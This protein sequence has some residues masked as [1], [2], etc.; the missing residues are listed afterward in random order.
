MP[1]SKLRVLI[2][3]LG[4]IG[5]RH[6]DNLATLGASLEA[7]SSRA[8]NAA[9]GRPLTLHRD[10]AQ[11]LKGRPD[12]VF[13]A[14]PT[15]LHAEY[16]AAAL[17]AGCHVYLEKPAAVSA[18]QA[19]PLAALARARKRVLAVGCQWRFNPCLE[20]V[21]QA[22]SEGELGT[23]LSASATMGEYL[24][25]Y[26]PG[27]DYRKGY[28]ARKDLGGGVLLTQIHDFNYL[29]WLF[30]PF[31]TAYAVGGKVSSLE[32]DVEDSVT[33]LLKSRAGVPVSAHVD[34]IQRKK[35]RSLTI[36]G[37]EG[38]LVWDAFENRLDQGARSWA[39][40]PLDRNAIFTAAVADF[41]ACVK[42][43]GRPRT[44]IEDAIADLAI[45]D[46][47]RQSMDT[48]RSVEVAA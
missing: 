14:N 36:V 30:G 17:E 18:A 40:G 28:A 27:E 8:E 25:D 21:R 11:A 29:A 1:A 39:E 10:Y 5:R 12:A 33:A 3:G 26:H 35:N 23:I 48:G 42:T 43:G 46:A 38:T 20:R 2:V 13:I 47:V 15:S 24:P 9:P 34:Y 19:A 16:A 4:S 41:L 22:L 6:A 37:S 7:V 44:S 45:V 32:L 31:S